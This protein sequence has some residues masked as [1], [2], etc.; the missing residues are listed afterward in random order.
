[1]MT[2]DLA[3]LNKKLIIHGVQADQT[4]LGPVESRLMHLGFIKNEPVTLIQKAPYFQIPILV[5][6]KGRR[7]ALSLEEAKKVQVEE[8]L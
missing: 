2:L 3:P 4:E 1:M 8:A 7:I 5:E 6:I